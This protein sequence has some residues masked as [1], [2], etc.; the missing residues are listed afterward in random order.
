[1]N[2][3]HMKY[4]IDIAETL[5]FTESAKRC[6]ITQPALSKAISQMEEELG[7]ALFKR[8]S[9]AVYLTPAGDVFYKDIKKIISDYDLAV[10]KS[11]N[12]ARDEASE[13]IIGIL[14]GTRVSDLLPNVIKHFERYYPDVSIILKNLSFG[15]LIK[16]LYDGSL[17][18]AITL[19]FEIHDKEKLDYEVLEETKDHIVVHKNHPLASAKKVSIADFK[20]DTFIMVNTQDSQNSQK[21]IFAAFDKA[22]IMPKIRYAPSIQTEMLWVQSGVGVCFL[23]SRNMLYENSEVKFLNVGGIG[24]PSLSICWNN[25]YPNPM[26]KLFKDLLI[27]DING[28]TLD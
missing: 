18:L 17:D 5:S 16:G 26:K 9:R 20:D 8:N 10:T 22:G 23:D 12:T 28:G 4:F 7:F 1:M 6:G 25:D 19:K 13:V 2:V 3:Q 14:E 15:A 24:D 27:Y 21:Q 11:Q